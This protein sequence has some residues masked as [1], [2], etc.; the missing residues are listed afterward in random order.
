MCRA[1]RRPARRPPRRSICPPPAARSRVSTD[2]S[3]ASRDSGSRARRQ[4]GRRPA[5]RQ[6]EVGRQE[7][8]RQEGVGQ[9]A[10]RCAAPGDQAADRGPTRGAQLAAGRLGRHAGQRDPD[11]RLFLAQAGRYRLAQLDPRLSLP[12]HAAPEG[13][14]GKGRAQADPLLPA[15][16]GYPVADPCFPDLPQPPLDPPQLYRHL[17]G[18]RSTRRAILPLPKPRGTT[19]MAFDDR[20]P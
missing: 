1:R 7:S 18:Q 3:P 14:D 9:E 19:R 11:W 10:P 15:A 12:R 17:I 20:Y 4:A 13:H 6:C 5:S 2:S 8:F 16:A